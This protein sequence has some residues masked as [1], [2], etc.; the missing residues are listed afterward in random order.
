M[1]TPRFHPICPYCNIAADLV[2]ANEVY[3]ST[4][5]GE[6]KIW[7]CVPCDA[8]VGCHGSTAVPLG[9]LA[10]AELREMR[11]RAH[12]VFDAHWRLAEKRDGCPRWQARTLA[13]KWLAKKLGITREACHI[14]MFDSFTCQKV[15][16]LSMGTSFAHMAQE[17]A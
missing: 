15:I 1:E 12:K 8:R 9:T 14:A 5:F 11:M 17:V 2:T 13:Y 10:N 3:G 7:R 4:K 6:K 16:E